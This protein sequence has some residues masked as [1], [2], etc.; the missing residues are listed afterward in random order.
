MLLWSQITK[1][2]FNNQDELSCPKILQVQKA[3]LALQA[4]LSCCYLTVPGHLSKWEQ[5]LFPGPLPL[6]SICLQC[7]FPFQ[8]CPMCAWDDSSPCLSSAQRILR[9]CHFTAPWKTLRKYIFM[10]IKKSQN[11]GAWKRPKNFLIFPCREESCSISIKDPQLLLLS[12]EHW[13]WGIQAFI[14]QPMSLLG[15]LSIQKIVCL[16]SFNCSYWY[17]ISRHWGRG[18]K[19]NGE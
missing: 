16:Q 3:W 10:T 11:L 8:H 13:R 9:H 12:G 6:L 14:R 5:N 15:M 2:W 18:P 4:H 1:R 19:C 7:V 17:I